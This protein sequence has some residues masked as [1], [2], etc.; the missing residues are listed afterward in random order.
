M[1]EFRQKVDEL[2]RRSRST[3]TVGSPIQLTKLGENVSATVRAPAWAEEHAVSLAKQFKGVSAYD[4]QTYSFQYAQDFEWDQGMDT[5]IKKA[6]FEEGISRGEVIDVLGIELRN[7][8]LCM[9]D[10]SV[11]DVTCR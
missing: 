6:A 3:M 5:L 10:I 4:I 2:V 9:M 11:P 7:E 1:A 8:I